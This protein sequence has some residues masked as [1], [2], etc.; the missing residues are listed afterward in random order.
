MLLLF[1]FK[2]LLL[3]SHY[4]FSS[5]PKAFSNATEY[6]QK[7][8]APKAKSERPAK[9]KACLK[10]IKQLFSTIYLKI[11]NF[12]NK[13]IF[14]NKNGADGRNEVLLLQSLLRRLI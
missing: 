7:A 4:F 10:K 3:L 14:F 1:L 6:I 2:E 13:I 11:I 5:K 9:A 8:F 12:G